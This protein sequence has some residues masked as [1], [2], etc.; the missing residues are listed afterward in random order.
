LADYQIGDVVTLVYTISASATVAL[1]V[2]APDGTVTTPTPTAGGS[3]PAVTY[4]H[5]Q[6]ATQAGT[7]LYRFAAT[8]AVTDAEEGSFYVVAAVS[9]HVY[10]SREEVKGRLSIPSAK[11][12]DHASIDSKIRVA[13]RMI[14]ADCQRHFWK[15]TEARTFTPTD[16]WSLELGAYNDLTAVTTLK[17]DAAGDGTFEQTWTTGDYQL[18]CFD[19]SANVNAGPQPRPYTQIRAVGGLLFPYPSFTGARGNLIEVTGTWGWPAVPEDIREA[20]EI[21]AAELFAL[22]DTTFGAA[23]VGDLGIIRV[24]K[25]TKYLE[26]INPY[27]KLLSFA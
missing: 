9:A 26:L 5:N 6:A 13:T 8:G 10:T 1:T 19:G 21:A 4:T 23:G 18:L 15:I 24:R 27:K 16:P 2:T 14:D 12:Q 11:T 25:N 20:A 7:W 3:P 22:K 17:T